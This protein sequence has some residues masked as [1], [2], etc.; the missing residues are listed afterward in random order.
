[1]GRHPTV[2]RKKNVILSFRISNVPGIETFNGAL[3]YLKTIAK[4]NVSMFTDPKVLTPESV[5]A[6]E[7]NGID[8]IITD[9]PVYEDLAEVLC[10]SK[11]PLVSIG[12]SDKSLFRRKDNVAFLEMDNEAIGRMAADH[13]ISLGRFRSF[14]FLPDL[15][16]TRWSEFRERGFSDALSAIGKKLQVFL[17]DFKEDETGYRKSLVR[18]IKGLPRPT[19]VLL[20]GDYRATDL[21]VACEEAGLHIPTDVAIL[22]VDNNP[23]LCEST[24][25]SLS[26][27]EPTFEMEGFEAAKTLDLLMRSRK[28]RTKPLII[29]FPPKRIVERESTRNLS[30][31]SHLVDRA[32]D[33][34]KENLANPFSARDVAKHLGVSLSLLSL[35]FQQYE[36]KS[37]R[38][39]IIE[40]RLKAVCNMLRNTNLPIGRIASRCGFNLTNR[41][42]HLFGERYGMSPRAYR[43]SAAQRSRTHSQAR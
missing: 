5:V 32:Y 28:V 34:I 17:T 29:R 13:F 11:I 14:G 37:V 33:F 9:H 42:T 18:W 39:T 22:G 8:G 15:T 3:R 4:W 38:E 25:P 40:H 20:V 24:T 16:P 41:L 35:R 23:I 21:F 1:M 2:T 31:G 6:A 43:A 30:P 36:K 19:A 26:S 10:K 12:N 7:R 27:I